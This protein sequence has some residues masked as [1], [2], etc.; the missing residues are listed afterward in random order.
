M[1]LP[2]KVCPNPRTGLVEP[3][4]ASPAAND[5]ASSAGTEASCGTKE[6]INAGEVHPGVAK[7]SGPA[8][9]AD[10][11]VEAQGVSSAQGPQSVCSRWLTVS[12]RS[13]TWAWKE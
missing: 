2:N 1:A 13:T 11:D 10:V 6:S 3:A 12:C 8:R 7:D 5:S 4:D 9:L